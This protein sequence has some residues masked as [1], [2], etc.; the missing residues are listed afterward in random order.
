MRRLT[1]NLPARVP[2]RLLGGEQPHPQQRHRHAEDRAEQHVGRRVHAQAHQGQ[3]GHGDE[4]GRGPAA[5][6]PPPAGRYQ[7]VQ[8][9]GQHDAQPL[10]LGRRHGEASPAELGRHPE[11]Q[12]PVHDKQESRRQQGEHLIADDQHQQPPEPAQHVSASRSTNPAM[13]VASAAPASA[14]TLATAVNP[15]TGAPAHRPSGRPA[16]GARRPGLVGARRRPS[17][18]GRRLRRRRLYWSR[19]RLL[20]LAW[21]FM[22]PAC[23]H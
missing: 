5:A 17:R 8:R 11:G 1:L 19:T 13:T 15:G 14:I 3:G 6:M 21:S 18:P 10:D 7:R 12:R 16:P 20:G 4:R 2:E 9:A 23:I 22:L